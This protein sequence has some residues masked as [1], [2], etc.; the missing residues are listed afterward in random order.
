MLLWSDY[1]LLYG[2]IDLTEIQSE[3]DDK[4]VVILRFD[5]AQGRKILSLLKRQEWHSSLLRHK[6]LLNLVKYYFWK[7]ILKSQRHQART[8]D[9]VVGDI[10]D[11]YVS[12]RSLIASLDCAVDKKK[13]LQI[14]FKAKS[15][16][17]AESSVLH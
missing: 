17:S 16:Q 3:F 11:F 15:F 10:C 4:G 5:L 9:P 2:A 7:P 1:I 13:G 8:Q 14:I 12:N 6:G